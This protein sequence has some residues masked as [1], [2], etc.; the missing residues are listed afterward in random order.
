MTFIDS[1][2]HLYLDAFD[3]DRHEVISRAVAEGVEYMLFPNIDSQT[4][5][6]LEET[7]RQYQKHCFPMM[8]L[9]PTHVTETYHQE[10]AVIKQHLDEKSYVAI[11]EIGID[12]YWD[13]TF[14]KEQ[15]AA[16]ETQIGWAIDKKMPIVIHA[17]DS[18][19]E[20]YEVVKSMNC[21]DLTGVFHC[22]TG[23]EQ[24]AGKALSLGGFM[25]GIGG[26]LTFKNSGLDQVIKDVGLEH[27]LLETD[28]PY[29][30]PTPYRGKRNESSYIPLIAKKLAAIKNISLE[31]VA[32][33]T[34][35][36]TRKLFKLPA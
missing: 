33:V 14:R 28:A 16:F 35:Q 9:H 12:L 34:T 30:A 6:R 31:Q 3:D 11:G 26:V 27:L 24:E 7:C 1:H 32:D 15:T 23:S 17:R 25:L 10:L 13:K 18:F 19:K 8:G 5:D 4:V 36:N 22:F 29:L 20:I 21:E 2:S